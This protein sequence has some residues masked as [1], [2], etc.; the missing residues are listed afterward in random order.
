MFQLTFT[1]QNEN[2]MFTGDCLFH[3]GVGMFFEGTPQ[4]MLNILVDVAQTVPEQTRLF[5]GHD[6]ALKNL[7]WAMAFVTENQSET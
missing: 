2:A 4:Q 3:G 1:S 6:Y 5:Y 7:H